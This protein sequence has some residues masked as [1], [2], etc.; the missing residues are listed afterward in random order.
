[1]TATP[2]EIGA[3]GK[4]VNLSSATRALNIK[5]DMERLAR[6]DNYPTRAR[7][8]MWTQFLYAVL[9]AVPAVV[10]I[11]TGH[12]WWS[13]LPALPSLWC[14]WIGFLHRNASPQAVYESGLLCGG[15]V[16][17]ES[18]LQIAVMAPMQ[19]SET[20]PT[21]W[22]VM[23]FDIKELPLHA[24]KKGERVPCAVMFGGA[25]PFSGLWSMMEPHPVCWATADAAL[26]GQAVQAIDEEEWRTLETLAPLAT[27]RSDRDYSK[28]VAYFNEDLSPRVDLQ[29]KPEVGQADTPVLALEKMAREYEEERQVQREE[30]KQSTRPDF[31]NA[32]IDRYF[33]AIEALY[34]R[35]ESNFADADSVR[36]L[37]DE[38]YRLSSRNI[39]AVVSSLDDDGKYEFS[40]YLA[41]LSIQWH[42][43]MKTLNEE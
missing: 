7:K 32:D 17:N 29:E 22:G 15:I 31:G 2:N 27:E 13:I 8:I 14:L 28:E 35:L 42:D 10:L 33:D 39:A 37:N 9:F 34:A 38:F 19:T 20:D 16:V 11:A 3:K 25:M 4:S 40:Q 43:K 41:K 26:V 12:I 6:Y 21:C 24:I 5:P 23:R 36:I 30:I 1:M 18:P